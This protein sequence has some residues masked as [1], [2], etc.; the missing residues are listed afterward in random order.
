[1]TS[2]FKRMTGLVLLLS[3][4]TILTFVLW[5]YS[6]EK[7]LSK[8]AQVSVIAPFADVDL[9]HKYQKSIGFLKDSGVIVGYE[10]E[11]FAPDK[12]LT[13][14]EFTKIVVLGT[15]QDVSIAETAP[16]SDVPLGEW[17]TNYVAFC[18]D[19]EYVKGYSDGTFKPDQSI[20]KTEAL[21]V[22]GELVKWD[23]DS[24]DMSQA[25]VSFKDVNLN[26]WYGPYLYYAVKMNIIDDTG[27]VFDPGKLI[28]RGQMAEYIYRDY[29]VRET[30]GP[31]DES[32]DSAF[33]T[34]SSG[35]YADCSDPEKALSMLGEEVIANEPNKDILTVYRRSKPVQSGDYFQVFA[36]SDP[37]GDIK[38][39]D[40]KS[41]FFW[42]DLNPGK[43][44]SHD[45]KMATVA[46]DGC[47]EKVYESGLWPVVN[48]EELWNTDVEQNSS[49]DLVYYGLNAPLV[50]EI[51][52]LPDP[53]IGPCNAPADSRKYAMIVFFGEDRS[54]RQDATNMNKFLCDQGYLT[55]HIDASAISPLSLISE[56]VRTIAEISQKPGKS[57]NSFFF[58]VT[59]HGDGPTGDLIVRLQDG[60]GPAGEDI[61]QKFIITLGSLTDVMNAWAFESMSTE[62]YT[63]AHNTCF[64]GNVVPLYQQKAQDAD[65]GIVGWISASSKSNQVSY[66]NQRLGSYHTNALISCI[67][68]ILP[69][70]N[71]SDCVKGVTRTEFGKYSINYDNAT[72]I[73]EKL[74]PETGNFVPFLP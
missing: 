71:F 47:A 33:I 69:Y 51:A 23:L 14:A 11:T 57:L 60:K 41:W 32:K 34:N 63:F 56:Q 49:E 4:G 44:F 27:D 22:L 62:T 73:I 29:V 19:L 45:T 54:I 59:S 66:T 18:A 16:F 2:G 6:F 35:Q 55:V 72:P 46:F 15:A 43:L 38:Y 65:S 64:S 39:V 52:A 74:T 7:S 20:S 8:N 58:F 48:G 13:R 25:G 30:D 61:K 70:E 53:V 42:I 9:S 17:Y 5:F 24:L 21:K 12:S 3:V 50:P 28:T 67:G 1:M 26:E 36:N 31:Y 37:K 68:D 10:D 40:E